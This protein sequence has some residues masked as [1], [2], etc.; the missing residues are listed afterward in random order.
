MHE[1]EETSQLPPQF[2]SYRSQQTDGKP[3]STAEFTVSENE[4]RCSNCGAVD[5][6][7]YKF[8]GKCGEKLRSV[9]T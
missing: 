8:C 6:S 7:D 3:T 4:T 1:P 9:N 5:E 2:R